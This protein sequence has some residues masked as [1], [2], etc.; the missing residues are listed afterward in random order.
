MSRRLSEDE[1][2]KS[3]M[4]RL[5][6]PIYRAYEGQAIQQRRSLSNLLAIVLEDCLENQEKSTEVPPLPAAGAPCADVALTH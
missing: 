5:P 2:K 4:V 6:L 3:V 1:I